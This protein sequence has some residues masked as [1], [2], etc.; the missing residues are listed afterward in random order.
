MSA[1]S[2][3]PAS[4]CYAGKRIELRQDAEIVV[5]AVT[6]VN[7]NRVG[8]GE[9]VGSFGPCEV[10]VVFFG[11]RFM[12]KGTLIPAVA[13]SEVVIETDFV[14]T[15]VRSAPR[16]DVSLIGTYYLRPPSVGIPMEILDL[17]ISGVAISPMP[18]L[19]P[20]PRQRQMISFHLGD[21]EIKAV[22]EMVT[23]EADRWRARFCK[24]ALSD[25]DAIARFVMSRQLER[26]SVLSALEIRTPSSLDLQTRLEFP[27]IES[28]SWTE[29]T[30]TL[31]AGSVSATVM[32]PPSARVERDRIGSL[33]GLARIGDP[34]DFAHLV[35]L[36]TSDVVVR[37]S[38]MTPYLVTCARHKGTSVTE[39]LVTYT[40]GLG[41][42][43]VKAIV[44]ELKALSLANQPSRDLPTVMAPSS[45]LVGC[46]C[47]VAVVRGSTPVS[48][49]AAPSAVSMGSWMDP[50]ELVLLIQGLES[51]A[52]RPIWPTSISNGDGKEVFE[53]FASLT[54][55]QSPSW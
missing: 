19:R 17:S 36:M 43:S 40:E 23:T 44:A 26:R 11:E 42:P 50:I 2:R 22:I 35:K 1:E 30:C 41:T 4:L 6:Q 18:D 49:T 38:V 39:V 48:V 7:G 21:R 28:I 9:R 33:V 10:M 45:E 20:S 47:G 52:V 54:A 25:E 8:V 12:A 27:L 24:L 32:V 55:G 5:T 51:V 37:D 15:N 16:V 3:P 34:R 13:G 31:W 29:D 46:S 14:P 53:A